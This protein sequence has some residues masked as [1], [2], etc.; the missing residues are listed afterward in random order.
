[1]KYEARVIPEGINSSLE[2][3]LKEAAILV[4]GALAV[5]AL[6]IV[7]IWYLTDYAIGYISPAME[8]SWFRQETFEQLSV[9][10]EHK[11]LAE[12]DEVEV[13]LM[14]L[15]DRLKTED[16]GD[17][18]FSIS[19]F[20]DTDPNAFILP[21][22]HIFVSSALFDSVESE[23]GL[24]MVLAHEMAHQYKRHPLRSTGRG[25]AMV[26]AL[27]L[28]FGNDE[29]EWIQELFLQGFSL[30]QLAFSREQEREADSLALKTLVDYYGHA[31]GSAEFFE[32]INVKSSGQAVIPVFYQSHP[33]IEERIAFLNRPGLDN[34]GTKT[35]LH[36]AIRQVQVE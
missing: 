23:N 34:Q 27:A 25:L 33:G 22:G 26:M 29:G 21:G 7:L 5:I 24:A 4:S 15:L 11:D 3:P 9:F 16:Y 28:V 32:R 36:P 14:L 8:R 18:E 13:Q 6:L 19:V 12:Y 30:G 17:F 1:M 35:K 2:N 20:R 10:S 31:A